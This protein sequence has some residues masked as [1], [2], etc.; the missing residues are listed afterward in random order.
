MTGT[1][2]NALTRPGQPSVFE[3][4]CRGRL[5]W[6]LLAPFPEQD[7]DDRVAG[8]GLVAELGHFLTERLDADQVDATRRLPD[9]FVDELQARG[10]LR[11]QAGSE[12]GGLDASDFTTFRLI[13][14]AASWSVPV[15]L[16]M[17]IQAAIGVGAYLPGLPPGPLRDLVIDRLRRGTVSGTADTEP[18]GAANRR[19][20][21]TATP[22]DGGAAYLLSGEKVHIGN[23]PIADLLA[24]TATVREPTGEATRLF[25]VDTDAPGFAVTSSHE[26]MGLK[27][28]PNAALTLDGVRVPA[29]RMLS[30]G[31]HER[32]TPAVNLALSRGR[33]YL[34]AAPSLAIARRCAQWQRS[35]ARRR[36]I[37]GRGLGRYDE[38]RRIVACSLADTFAID[39]V[40]EWSLLGRAPV[41]LLFEQVIGKNIASV[42]CWRVVE[43]TMSL[44]AAEG[45][46]TAGSKARRGAPA[47]SLERFH[48]DARGLRISGGVDFQ[49]DNWIG[50]RYVLSYYY[51]PPEDVAL[52][53]SDDLGLGDLTGC[54]LSP[55]NLAHLRFT[56]AEV[57]R[58]A[59][60]CLR[61]SRAHPDPEE[62]FAR[63]RL[64][65][66][67]SQAASEL[68][69]MALVLARTAGMRHDDA[70]ALADIYCSA[71]RHRL[72]DRWRRALAEDE[73]DHGRVSDRW[74]EGGAMDFL[75]RDLVT[76]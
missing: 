73:P 58:L 63:E 45:Y 43:R 6:D 1:A 57:R 8:D 70:Q 35:F 54:G 10:Y 64:T 41:N 40:A 20:C 67:V 61:L 59:R 71:A 28:F 32:L 33:M 7:P 34:I 25:F 18:F 15:A 17:A 65:I 22:T 4:L 52:I 56:A 11:L 5:R 9:G 48:R 62:L 49:L 23:G 39:S 29:E 75:A 3:D 26:F 74:L 72:A 13:E 53:E 31:R 16:V 44:L 30:E 14:A 51:P 2:R 38:P 27:G 60:E 66:L 76:P 21:T 42:L 68:L 50:R 55:R 36:S 46:E 69:T 12:L 24:V 19:R 37:D 47:L